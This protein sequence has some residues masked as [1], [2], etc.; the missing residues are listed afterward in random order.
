E[1]FVIFLFTPQHLTQSP[2][3]PGIL[4]L[5]PFIN[6]KNITHALYQNMGDEVALHPNFDTRDDCS[7]RVQLA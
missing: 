5:N 4:T 6:A 3:Y 1:N 2:N 7:K